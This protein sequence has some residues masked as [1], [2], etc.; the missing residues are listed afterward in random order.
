MKKLSLLF[1]LASCLY[2]LSADVYVGTTAALT[3]AVDTA[4]S[5]DTIWVSNGTYAISVPTTHGG[6][7]I[8]G[9]ITVR[10]ITGLPKDVL[11]YS[12][13]GSGRVVSMATNATAWLIGVTVSNGTF[14]WGHG[15]GIGPWGN[16]NTNTTRGS[17]S[18]CIIKNNAANNGGNSGG[19]AAFCIL[20][21][22]LLNDN[23]ATTL[24]SGGGG[25]YKSLLYNC[26]IVSNA[27][28]T[29]SGGVHDGVLYNCIS[30]GN[31]PAGDDGLSAI[32][33]SCGEGT[34]YD[35]IN[36]NITNNPV[37]VSLTDFHL[38]SNSPCIDVGTNGSWTTGATDLDGS[39]RIYNVIVDMGTYEFRIDSPAPPTTNNFKLYGCGVAKTYGVK[40]KKIYGR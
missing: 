33:Y 27:A 10:S 6:L 21:N 12:T 29:L 31:S 26:T 24:G 16:L 4:T 5:G 17:V 14:P 3:A 30:Y 15:G 20:Y 22:C 9:G 19:G 39:N 23:S 40:T 36:N 34:N 37:F 28:V 8:G 25:S 35:G 7:A 2:S 32:Y 1:F 11:F 13:D 18:N 38:Q